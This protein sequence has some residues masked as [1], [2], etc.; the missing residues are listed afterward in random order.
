MALLDS[1]ASTMWGQNQKLL[2]YHVFWRIY[3]TFAPFFTSET[4]NGNEDSKMF[5]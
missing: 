3:S 4:G 2:L 5:R 1:L